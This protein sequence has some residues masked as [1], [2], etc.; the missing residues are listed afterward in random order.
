MD[1]IGTLLSYRQPEDGV[2]VEVE[3]MLHDDRHVLDAVGILPDAEDADAVDAPAHDE[4]IA[5]WSKAAM[6][7][8]EE[9]IQI[10]TVAASGIDKKTEFLFRSQSLLTGGEYIF[11]TDDSGIGESHEKPTIKEKLI[12]EYLNDCLI[13]I[14]DSYHQGK[15]ISPTPYSQVGQQPIAE[16]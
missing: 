2:A 14:I 4:K 11:L 12:V 16:D 3:G 1:I 13:R 6:K 7:A 15:T 9:G 5:N 10:M 8:A